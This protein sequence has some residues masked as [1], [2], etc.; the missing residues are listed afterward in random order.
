MIVDCITSITAKI[1]LEEKEKDKVHNVS[2][3]NLTEPNTRKE[4]DRILLLS[5]LINT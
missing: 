1:K 2:E 4:E 3:S 5:Y